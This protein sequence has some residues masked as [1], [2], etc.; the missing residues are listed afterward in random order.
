[1]PSGIDRN[2]NLSSGP[3]TGRSNIKFDAVVAVSLNSSLQPTAVVTDL[4]DGD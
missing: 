3:F 2:G 4:V 1:M